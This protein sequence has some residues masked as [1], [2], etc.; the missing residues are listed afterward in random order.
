MEPTL[1][2]AATYDNVYLE[3]GMWWAELYEKPLID[4]C[5]G[6]EKLLWG[7]DWGASMPIYY[8][9]GHYP[10]GYVSQIRRRGIV[11]HQVD[12]FGWSLRQLD[13]LDL[14]QDDLNLILGGNAARLYK[15]ETPLTRMFKEYIP[16]ERMKPPGQ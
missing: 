13:K 16:R 7:T 3:C 15:I 9:L 4:P 5:I 2:L 10:P 8:Q 6:P 11:A 14:D 12:Y 1:H